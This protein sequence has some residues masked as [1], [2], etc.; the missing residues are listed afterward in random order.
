MSWSWSWP[1]ED[2]Q[3]AGVDGAADD[4]LLD[5]L[6]SYSNLPVQ[7]YDEDPYT[8]F[9]DNTW[10]WDVAVPHA[11]TSTPPPLPATSSG[12]PPHLDRPN[13]SVPSPA[14]EYGAHGKRSRAGTKRPRPRNSAGS[15]SGGSSGGGGN[16]EARW[17]EKLLNPCATAIAAGNFSRAQHLLY[18]LDELASFSGDANHRLA[19]HGLQ[20]LSRYVPP[21]IAI[22]TSAAPARTFATVDLKLFHDS[23]LRFHENSPWFSFPNTVANAAILQA[24][25]ADPSKGA[26]AALHIVDIG[27]SHGVQW[28]TLLEALT[29]RPARKPA[30]VRLTVVPHAASDLPVPFSIA[31]PGHDFAKSL[32]LFADKL[33]LNLQIQRHPAQTLASEFRGGDGGGDETV[34]VC[35]QF[36]LHHLRHHPH[37][38]DGDGG[39]DRTD[40]LRLLAEGVRPDLMVLSEY[41][42]EYGAGDFAAGFGRR[43]EFVR[44]FL[45]AASAAF[46]GRESEER[47]V[48]EGEAATAL[49]AAAGE[50]REGRERWGRRMSAAGFAAVG[51]SDEAVDGG[52]ALLR[53]HDGGWEMKVEG[54]GDGPISL[55]WKGQPILFV[56]LWRPIKNS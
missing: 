46:K 7:F 16:K 20:A 53:K 13:T 31:P 8:T 40:F 5:W 32:L 26:G 18:V 4:H 48:V 21:S 56:S 14:K 3:A 19:A 55:L 51:F 10:S 6:D 12:D 43:V 15:N 27:V 9:P 39:D 24:L 38:E 1:M 22:G 45:E 29:R 30:A 28:P 36:R 25:A 49:V 35:A 17:A 33:H 47:R 23:L 42:G 37:S 52:R 34:V 44:R 2:E 54:G 11:L 41:D 50:M